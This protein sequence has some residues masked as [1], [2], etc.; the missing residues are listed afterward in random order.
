MSLKLVSPY[1]HGGIGVTV[2]SSL[3]PY[4]PYST[5]LIGSPSSV[6]LTPHTW[7]SRSTTSAGYTQSRGT[8]TLRVWRFA[9][10]HN[11]RRTG[12]NETG[13]EQEYWL[14]DILR[15]G[16]SK[17]NWQWSCGRG[18]GCVHFRL[19]IVG[20]TNRAFSQFWQLADS[21]GWSHILL[22]LCLL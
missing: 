10:Q 21:L 3:R 15:A 12:Y 6:R 22:P 11:C 7:Y 5:K 19:L 18:W 16:G 13:P 17:L 9:T 8:T 1:P 20:G 2:P 4:P 14:Q